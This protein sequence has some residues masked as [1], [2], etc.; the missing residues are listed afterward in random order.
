MSLCRVW[1]G[2]C[3]GAGRSRTQRTERIPPLSPL[4]KPDLWCAARSKH[5]VEFRSSEAYLLQTSSVQQLQH[6][7]PLRRCFVHLLLL[8][9]HRLSL[10]ARSRCTPCMCRMH[11]SLKSGSDVWLSQS[12]SRFSTHSSSLWRR[13]IVGLQLVPAG[14]RRN[15]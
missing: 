11:T 6:S 15:V 8:Y 1:R 14:K 4:E 13:L 3:V 7:R 2:P 10:C 9:F 5:D 12:K